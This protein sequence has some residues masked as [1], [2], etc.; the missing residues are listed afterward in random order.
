MELV[1]QFYHL[2][3]GRINND[4]PIVKAIKYCLFTFL[5]LL[6]QTMWFNSGKYG[7]SGGQEAISTLG[8]THEVQP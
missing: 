8:D 3:D 6:L 7:P 5:K 4:L 2:I 1:Q